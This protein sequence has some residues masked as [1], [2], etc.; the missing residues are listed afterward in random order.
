MPTPRLIAF[1]AA[2]FF[3]E[4]A[5]NLPPDTDGNAVK[6][7]VRRGSESW[8]RYFD[9]VGRIKR[10]LLSV[11]QLRAATRGRR[12]RSLHFDLSRS[13]HFELRPLH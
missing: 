12:R 9:D 4:I 2:A 10:W 1:V 8:P 11:I 13:L 6:V 7:K 5:S 3:A